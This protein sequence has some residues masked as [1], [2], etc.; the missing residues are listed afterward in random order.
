M[1]KRLTGHG[2]GT[3]QKMPAGCPRRTESFW[4][5]PTAIPLTR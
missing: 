3:P 2:R 4:M 1:F 5:H